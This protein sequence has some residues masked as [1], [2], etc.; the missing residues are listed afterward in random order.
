MH[1]NRFGYFNLNQKNVFR[2]L[3]KTAKDDFSNLSSVNLVF[4]ERIEYFRFVL[5]S[6]KKYT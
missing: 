2:F 6:M 5:K 4:T 1:Q 3:I